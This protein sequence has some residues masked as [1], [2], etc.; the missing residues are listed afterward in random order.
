MPENPELDLPEFFRDAFQF[1]P[2]LTFFVVL[3]RLVIAFALGCIIAVAYRV[4]RRNA[5]G[6]DAV[7]LMPTLVL[8][9]IIIAMVTATI[10]NSVARAFSLV[11]ALAI[12]RFRTVVEDTRDTA[13]VIFA[14]AVG[15]AAGAGQ[16]LVPVIGIPVVAAAAFLFR[17]RADG[18]SVQPASAYTLTVRLGAGH[19]AET[20]LKPVF[21]AHVLSASLTTIGSARQGAAFDLAYTLRLRADADVTAFVTALNS[22]QGVQSVELRRGW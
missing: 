19:S 15:M 6:N 20:L 3:L 11:G 9:T 13:F 2:K 4:T 17:P 14:V 16:L 18:R 22:L 1:D 12:V 21:D 5:A 8:L 10:G 7:N